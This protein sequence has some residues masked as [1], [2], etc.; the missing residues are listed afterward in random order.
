MSNKFTVS[1]GLIPLSLLFFHQI[2]WISFAA[3]LIAIP[4]TGF[5]ILPLSLLGSLLSL[6]SSVLGT[7]CQISQ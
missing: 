7:S 5:L 6:V 2:S 1:L 3:N 4:S